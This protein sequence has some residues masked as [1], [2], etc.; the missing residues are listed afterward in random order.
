MFESV[1]NSSKKKNV[2]LAIPFTSANKVS[3]VLLLIRK[4]EGIFFSLPKWKRT[5]K[6]NLASGFRS[7]FIK[8]IWQKKPIPPLPLSIYSKRERKKNPQNN[9]KTVLY[10][11]I[12]IY[13][14][15]RLRFD[16][17]G[18]IKNSIKAQLDRWTCTWGGWLVGWL[19][20]SITGNTSCLW[21]NKFV[22]I[23]MA[24]VDK[25]KNNFLALTHVCWVKFTKSFEADVNFNSILFF[26]WNCRKFP[27]LFD[28]FDKKKNYQEDWQ[29][30]QNFSRTADSIDFPQALSHLLS[31]SLSLSYSLS[32]SI[33]YIYMYIDM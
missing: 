5:G 8:S 17:K 33:L 1:R 12:D 25:T 14:R 27:H 11:Y 19:V 32:L 24:I 29:R 6:K 4:T 9:S 31:L 2:H 15:C 23:A 30:R 7:R 3:S 13:I 10:M 20:G 28:N 26:I 22:P 21:R 16:K 18:T